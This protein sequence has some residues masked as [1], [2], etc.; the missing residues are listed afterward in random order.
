MKVILVFVCVCMFTI[1]Q[2]VHTVTFEIQCDVIEDSM[3]EWLQV[4]ACVH[5]LTVNCIIMAYGLALGAHGLLIVY[6]MPT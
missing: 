2:G 6:L 5:T 1:L 3:D 4:P